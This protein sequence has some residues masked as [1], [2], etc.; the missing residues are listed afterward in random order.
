VL[1][2]RKGT[3][4]TPSPLSDFGE[5]EQEGGADGGGGQM[6]AKKGGADGGG[7]KREEWKG[8][9]TAEGHSVATLL[10]SG[11]LVI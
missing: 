7:S 8:W 2:R 9:Q 4:L 5:G 3:N 11:R 6:A 10:V 1:P